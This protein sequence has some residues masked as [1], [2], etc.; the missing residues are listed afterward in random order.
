MQQN[1]GKVN[2]KM[3]GN[4]V[5]GRVHANP[6]VQ[7]VAEPWELNS[8]LY[9]R[10]NFVHPYEILLLCYLL[11]PTKDSNAALQCNPQC[12]S[13]RLISPVT[14]FYSVGDQ[15][16]RQATSSDQRSVH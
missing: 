1:A 8:S 12:A 4:L 5:V 6:R 16:K 14:D 7:T 2:E 11:R 9:M 3:G 15:A 13:I 10:V